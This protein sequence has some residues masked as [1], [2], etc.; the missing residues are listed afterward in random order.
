MLNK[1]LAKKVKDVAEHYKTLYIM[2]AIGQPLNESNKK[3]LIGLYQYNRDK[4]A[5]INA[6]SADT[7]GFDCV[8]F[9]KSVG[10]WGWSGDVGALYGGATYASN[11]MPDITVE[12]LLDRCS[13]IS[14]DFSKIPIGAFVEN[15]GHCGIY[16][17]G[18]LVVECNE[19]HTDNVFISALGNRAPINGYP[20][21]TWKR[22]GMLPNVEYVPATDLKPNDKVTLKE[23]ALIYGQNC[24]FAKWV[25]EATLEVMEE[26]VNERVVFS[27]NGVLVGAAYA[28]DLVKVEE[29]PAVIDEPVETPPVELKGD[30][31][32]W[33][34]EFWVDTAERVVYTICETALGVMGA[35]QMI[36]ELNWKVV[37]GASALAGITTLFKCLVVGLKK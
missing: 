9:V 31:R 25:Y 36:Q 12:A 17:G 35:T 24:G 18:G 3:F 10:Y 7:F 4:A 16:I 2:G 28:Q 8:C 34:K 22:W 30:G 37:F 19:L 11:G 13:G 27:H 23:G 26:P 33:T 1:E 20:T 6:A 32:M 29:L 5:K 15:S 14:S 21:T